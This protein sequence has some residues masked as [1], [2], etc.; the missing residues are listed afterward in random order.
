[1][2]LGKLLVRE[3]NLNNHEETLTVWIAHY[4]AEL[5][6]KAESE[7]DSPA[8]RKTKSEASSLVFK[9]WEHRNELSGRA[10]PMKQYEAAVKQLNSM[11]ADGSFYYGAPKAKASHLAEFEDSSRK[12]FTSL[13]LLTLP[14]AAA[15]TDIAHKHLS[16]FEKKIIKK[17][18]SERSRRF[19]I[20]FTSHENLD[21][22]AVRKNQ[23][24]EEIARV[25]AALVKIEEEVDALVDAF[26]DYDDANQNTITLM[27]L[28]EDI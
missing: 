8:G 21:P 3:T 15:K 5:I 17:L 2:E 16:T 1:L 26:N 28:D 14:N 22:K 6:V 18:D 24:R 20:R 27:G 23:I 4:L 7:G 10:N 12:L 19:I 9:L 25:R 11:E 13:F